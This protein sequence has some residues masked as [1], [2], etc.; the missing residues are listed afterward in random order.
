[1]CRGPVVGRAAP[2]LPPWNLAITQTD[3][4]GHLEFKGKIFGLDV[5]PIDTPTIHI[6]VPQYESERNDLGLKRNIHKGK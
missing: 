6:P 1:M 5:G 3:V 4:S 2:D